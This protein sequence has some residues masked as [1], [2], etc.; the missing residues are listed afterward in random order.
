MF[1]FC[2]NDCI[3]QNHSDEVADR[4]LNNSLREYHKLTQQFPGEIDGIVTSHTPSSV[5]VSQDS[6]LHDCISRIGN[7]ALKRY[8]FSIFLKF[9]VE[10]HYMI[11][12]ET[13]LI[14]NNFCINIGGDNYNAIYPFV[15]FR[16]KGVLF[17]LSVHN[18]ICKNQI[19]IF[20]DVAKVADVDNL[21]GH[22]ENTEYITNIIR[23]SKYNKMDNLGKLLMIIG[24]NKVSERFQKHFANYPVN[25]QQAVIDHFA[26]AINRNLHTRFYPDDKLIKDV[27]PPK[28]SDIKVFE[29]RIFN[30]VGCR[31]YF[32]ETPDCVYLGSIENKPSKP[33][34]TQLQDSHIMTARNIIRELI[35]L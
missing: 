33:G 22:C 4:C 25:I 23:Q 11:D 5:R 3:P 29:L 19:P 12:N 31:V 16:N 32:Y 20:S 6:S 15:V 26:E 9:P 10:P 27:T 7:H 2:F 13:E 28:E 21:F 34:R 35:A 14:E 18:D 24:N 1:V 17:S 8:A 30:P